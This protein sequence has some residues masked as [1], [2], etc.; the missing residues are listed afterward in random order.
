LRRSGTDNS[1]IKSKGQKK[2]VLRFAAAKSTSFNS[3][4]FSLQ[5]FALGKMS[6][7]LV[8]ANNFIANP[9][10]S[11]SKEVFRPSQPDVEI[12]F[13]SQM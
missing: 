8:Q 4:T 7:F 6:S 2:W 13:D 5:R 9:T 3:K 1:E 12:A 10:E 11:F